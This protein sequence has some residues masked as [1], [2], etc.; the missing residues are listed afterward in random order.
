MLQNERSQVVPQLKLTELTGAQ[1]E[2]EMTEVLQTLTYPLWLMV[3]GA[4][5]LMVG[6]VGLALEKNRRQPDPERKAK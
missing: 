2:G 1:D 4:L 5:M 6:L 3:A